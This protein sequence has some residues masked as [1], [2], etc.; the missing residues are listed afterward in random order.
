M[1]ELMSYSIKHYKK[2]IERL[3]YI[4][5][6]TNHSKKRDKLIKRIEHAE[7]MIDYDVKWFNNIGQWGE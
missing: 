3:E 7:K 1:F 2:R 5:K 4:L 6:Y